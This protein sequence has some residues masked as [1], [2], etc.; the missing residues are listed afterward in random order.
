MIKNRMVRAGEKIIMNISIVIFLK[1]KHIFFYEYMLILL[2]R[3][4]IKLRS[5]IFTI[6][7]VIIKYVMWTKNINFNCP[8]KVKI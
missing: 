5:C 7:K 1:I 2:Y 3:Q 6:I 4:A 8:L